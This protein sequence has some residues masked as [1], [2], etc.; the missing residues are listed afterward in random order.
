MT[1]PQPGVLPVVQGAPLD[2]TI[3]VEGAAARWPDGRE[4]RGQIRAQPESALVI[5]DMTPHLTTSVDGADVLVEL[6]LTGAQTRKIVDGVFDIFVAGP[7]QTA[8]LKVWG[9]AVKVELAVT[10]WT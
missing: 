10:R 2:L 8:P 3:T 7:E 4:A 6:H 5:F 9:G 1:T